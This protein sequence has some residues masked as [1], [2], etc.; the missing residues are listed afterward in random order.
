MKKMLRI[1]DFCHGREPARIFER[2][3]GE[4]GENDQFKL[5]CCASLRSIMSFLFPSCCGFCNQ[6]VQSSSETS[7]KTSTVTGTIFGQRKGHVNFCI[8]EDPRS[9]PLLLLE[10]ST[11]TPRLAKEMQADQLRIVLECE[12]TKENSGSPLFSEPMW[13]M[14]CNGR[15]V[16]FAIKKH[17]LN[18][19][20]QN[21]IEL[22]QSI[23]TGAGI[24][25]VMEGSSHEEDLV[26]MRAHYERVVSSVDSQAFHMISPDCTSNQE[27]SIFF[28]RN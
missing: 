2:T 17:S 3:I 9:P 27:F 5:G 16:G 18:S 6:S 21:A 26:Y 10:F 12:K 8:Q 25:P 23:S 28:V 4:N 24:V 20:D 22:M 19:P 1:V 7:C 13:G 15:R 14:F 11:P